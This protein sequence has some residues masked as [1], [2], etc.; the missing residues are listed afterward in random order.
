MMKLVPLFKMDGTEVARTIIDEEAYASLPLTHPWRLAQGYAWTQYHRLH[1]F[2]WWLHNDIYPRVPL[3]DHKDGNRLN[4]RYEN[5]RE[6]TISQNAK[7]HKEYKNNTS[8]HSGVYEVK[9][10][11]CA[12]INVNG[13]RI[14]LGGYNTYNLAVQAR[15]DAEKKYW[16]E[17][18]PIR[19]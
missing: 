4:N 15:E 2:V 13:K 11:Y 19:N 17:F 8:G 1:T 6:V 5:L 10:Y 9:N 7:N 14:Y 3:L 18:A 16:K 12:S